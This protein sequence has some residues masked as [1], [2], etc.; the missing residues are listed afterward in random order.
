LIPRSGLKIARIMGIDIVINPTWLLIFVLVAYLLGDTLN[1]PYRDFTVIGTNSFPGGPWPWIAGILTAAVIFVC[2][3]A[4]ELSH[5]FVA[6]RNGISIRRITLFIFGGVAEMSEDVTDAR[7][8]LKMAI[9][10]PLMSF[11]LGALFIGMYWLAH[12][13]QIPA[14]AAPLLLVGGFNM[15]VAVFNLLPGF[16]LDGGRVFR[17]AVWRS[18]GDLRKATRIASTGGQLVAGGLVIGGLYLLISD[19]TNNSFNGFWLIIIGLFLFQLARASYQ[20]TLFR[21]A[22]SDTTVSD[23]MYTDVPVIDAQT[24]LTDLRNHYFSSFSL[25]AFPVIDNGRLVGVVGRDDLTGVA[26]S[27][28]DVLNAGRIAR[29]LS[30]GQAVPPET[31]LDR[32]LRTMMSTQEFLLVVEQ[33]PEAG[34]RVKGVLTRDELMRYV[35]A[36]IKPTTPSQM[37]GP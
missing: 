30:P 11:A 29:P 32:V 27:E 21:I 18:T 16:P 31:P 2:L 36:R 4:H 1:T 37:D 19:L 24:T 8:E 6:K 12:L 14:L 9:A 26:L 5:S 15:F 20:Q 34:D 25:P 3:L 23:I 33:D 10:G 17:A 13:A 22:A 28:W 7:V 35:Q